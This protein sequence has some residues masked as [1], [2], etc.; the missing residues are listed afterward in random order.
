MAKSIKPANLGAAIEQEL[1]V[2]HESV[3]AKIDAAGA[4]A[5]KKL[6]KLTKATAPVGHRGKFKRSITSGVKDQTKRG[7]TYVWYV[8]SPESR[9]AHLLAHGHATKNGGRTKANPF[10]QNACDQ[11]LPEYE[12]AV[13]EALKG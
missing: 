3:T 5:V 7:N 6:A 4:E 8:K 2:Y 13:E 11:V 10:L 1:T 9:L 12:T